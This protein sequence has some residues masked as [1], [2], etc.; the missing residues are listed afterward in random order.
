MSLKTNTELVSSDWMEY[1]TMAWART[2]WRREGRTVLYRCNAASAVLQDLVY[3]AECGRQGRSFGKLD[4]ETQAW[5]CYVGWKGKGR[6]DRI[7]N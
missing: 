2:R 3:V 7:L 4:W 6:D 5:Y 1:A